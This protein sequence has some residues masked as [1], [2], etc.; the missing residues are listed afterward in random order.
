MSG[1]S[2]R[3]V[4]IT[5]LDAPAEYLM[6]PRSA[7]SMCAPLPKRLRVALHR[8]AIGVYDILGEDES[9]QESLWLIADYERVGGDYD[10]RYRVTA[11]PEREEG[12]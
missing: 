2:D 6:V 10:G 5:F 12:G 8:D 3:I 7:S 1:R 11:A 9:R 4:P